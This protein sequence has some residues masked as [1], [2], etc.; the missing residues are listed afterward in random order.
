M[1]ILD[2]KLA[3][4]KLCIDVVCKRLKDVLKA[5]LKA[6]KIN[7]NT[8]ENRKK[9]TLEIQRVLNVNESL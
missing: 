2:F 5:A 9:I 6:C 7:P 4:G 1:I 3:N 8:W